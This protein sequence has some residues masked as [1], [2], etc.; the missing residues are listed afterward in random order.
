MEANTVLAD[1]R[2]GL[3]RSPETAANGTAARVGRPEAD[4]PARATQI[5]ADVEAKKNGA[6]KGGNDGRGLHPSG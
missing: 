3:Q 4:V 5:L 6:G 1:A 2:G